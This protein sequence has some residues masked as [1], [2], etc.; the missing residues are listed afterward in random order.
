MNAS[1]Y[2]IS[3]AAFILCSTQTLAQQEAIY[4]HFLNNMSVLNPAYTG[5][6]EAAN[7]TL[8]HRSQWVGFEGAPT[9]DYLMFDTPL[10][11]DE[12]AIGGSFLFDKIGPST[13]LGLT[14]DAAYRLRLTNRSTLAFGLKGTMSMYQINLMDLDLISDYYGGADQVFDYNPGNLFVPNV[15]FGIMYYKADHFIGISSPRILKNKISN[16][17]MAIYEN[18]EGTTQ[19]TLYLTGGKIFKINR[20][21][22]LKTSTLIRG[23]MNAPA[24]AGL[25]TS[26][27]IDDQI[28][29]GIFYFFKEVAGAY[30][31]WSPTK[32]WGFGYSFDF[33]TNALITTNYGSHEISVNYFLNGKRKRIVYPRYF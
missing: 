31:I 33:A 18:L 32:K 27:L 7:A 24:S 17:A 6:R 5:Y 20:H 4:A 2:I 19:P 22:K 15:G 3:W 29:A 8:I 9:T 14:I 10:S 1:K 28:D 13:E 12:M 16:K 30:A 11:W 23:T 21:V 25:Y 26:I